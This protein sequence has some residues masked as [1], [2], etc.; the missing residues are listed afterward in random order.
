MGRT[1]SCRAK[2]GCKVHPS[3]TG[4]IAEFS[5][6][7]RP[8]K[9]GFDVV[10]GAL[11]SPFRKGRGPIRC[12]SPTP[13]G[14]KRKKARSQ[15]YAYAIDEHRSGWTSIVINLCQQAGQ[16]KDDGISHEMRVKKLDRTSG[17]VSID[18]CKTLGEKGLGEINTNAIECVGEN[19][20]TR[21]SGTRYQDGV[22][23]NFAAY[24]LLACKEE[25]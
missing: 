1:S 18:F 25:F 22:H 15:R 20:A 13:H 24:D 6:I 17:R 21:F 23:L 19:S 10:D 9:V 2:L 16:L 8:G 5:Q 12:E 14:V 7:D 11:E 3:Q 4:D